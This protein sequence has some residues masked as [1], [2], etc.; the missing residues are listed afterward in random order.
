MPPPTT[1][2]G[3]RARDRVGPSRADPQEVEMPGGRRHPVDRALRE[4]MAVRRV[5]GHD[6]I[7]SMD[8]AINVAQGLSRR[9]FLKAGG[10]MAAGFALAACDPAP[11]PTPPVR[12]SNDAGDGPRIAVVGAGLA[13]LTVAYQLR[14]AGVVCSVFEARDRVGGR[15]WSARDFAGGQVAEHGGEF[16]DTRHV[17]LRFLARELGLELDDLWSAWVPGSTWLSFVDG[18]VVRP[19]E[20]F[21]Q[22]EPAVNELMKVA[23]TGSFFAG[24]A[25][26]EVSVLDEQSEAE[27]YAEHVGPL[28]TPLYR[29]WTQGQAGWY[30]LDPD[31]L[32]AANLIDFYGVDY[33]GADE[34]YTIRGGN[35]QV[36][37]RIL[38]ELPQGTV[39]LETPL[40]ALR[41]VGDGTIELRFDDVA[42]PVIADRVVLTVPFT[43]LREVDLSASGF[44]PG[45]LRAVD[46]LSMG[47]NAK[48]LMQFDRPFYTGF[49]D[50]SGGMDRG[51]DP[52]LGTWESGGTDPGADRFG[53]LT[54]YSGGRVGAGY[55]TEVAHAPAPE[56]IV[57]Q[58]LDAIDE[59]VSWGPLGV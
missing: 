33:P 21:D 13:G 8:E 35:D 57:D 39:T 20:L 49:D 52:I 59:V 23:R 15:C 27:W 32:S 31:R 45:R 43:A 51:D 56:I 28:G 17:H 18:A 46:E 1:P 11:G 55:A 26:P 38:E 6:Q 16:I 47:T 42:A 9:Q 5:A 44:S 19:R 50:W 30:G 53:L 29:L 3:E 10:V 4:L 41:A 48:L 12:P 37:A 14:R 36:P 25:S 22:M 2:I 54:V 7:H 34:R 58:T 40:R 24:T